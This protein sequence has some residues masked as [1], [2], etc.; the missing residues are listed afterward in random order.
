MCGACKRFYANRV[1]ILKWRTM[2]GGTC[3]VRQ[4]DQN[5]HMYIM[6]FSWALIPLLCLQ[7]QH[8]LAS[9]LLCPSVFRI[10]M[11]RRTECWGKGRSPTL[12]TKNNSN[13]RNNSIPWGRSRAFVRSMT[14]KPFRRDLREIARK[15]QS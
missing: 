10:I 14:T 9:L 5:V 12:S 7:Q 2:V 6:L 13:N 11:R 8:S 15:M 4:L 1:Y 3:T